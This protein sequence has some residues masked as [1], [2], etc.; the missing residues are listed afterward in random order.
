MLWFLGLPRHL[1]HDPKSKTHILLLTMLVR[2]G[3]ELA[4]FGQ[5][6]KNY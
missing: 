1:R 5:K 2:E 3:N 4:I 6:I